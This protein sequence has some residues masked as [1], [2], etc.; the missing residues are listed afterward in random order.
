[1]QIVYQEAAIPKSALGSSAD[2]SHAQ[3]KG[4]I[5]S[6][7]VPRS[8]IFFGFSQIGS[9]ALKLLAVFIIFEYGARFFRSLDFGLGPSGF[10][11]SR[12]P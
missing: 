2:S 1:M 10:D 4:S 8:L 12:G 7:S 6:F 9:S 11:L 5:F 3:T